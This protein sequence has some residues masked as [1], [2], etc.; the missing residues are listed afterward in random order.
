MKT[1]SWVLK[2]PW[3]LGTVPT[4]PQGEVGSAAAHEDG[5]FFGKVGANLWLKNTTE[6]RVIF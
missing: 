2:A 5:G 3:A 1:C 4:R 6:D